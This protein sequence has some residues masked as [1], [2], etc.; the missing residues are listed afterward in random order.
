MSGLDKIISQIDIDAKAQAETVI[1]D[2]KA[3][4]DK[5]IA[6]AEADAKTKAETVFSQSETRSADIKERADSAAQLERRNQ[7]LKFKQQYIIDV[8]DSTRSSLSDLPDDAYFE[9]L[10]KL[11][12]KY[13]QKESATMKLN[14]RDLARVPA[15][16]VK[17]ATE[18]AGLSSGQ[19][20]T[21]SNDT[22]DIDG[23]FLLI[24]DGIDINCSFEALFE[25]AGDEL[26]DCAQKVLFPEG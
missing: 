21:V 11:V 25:D 17:K 4:A 24:Y 16:F 3:K 14:S 15:D 6:K 5:I 18:A 19:E 2:A 20:I 9:M 1:A 22:C 13:A 12:K 8:I 26:R 7:M 23:G 10:L